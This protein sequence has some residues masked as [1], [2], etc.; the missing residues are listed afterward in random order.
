MKPNLFLIAAPRTGSTQLAFLLAS[1]PDV[2]IPPIKE[3]NFFSQH[4]YP[5]DFVAMRHLNDVDPAAYVARKSAKRMQFA[6]F[7]EQ[8]HYEYLF[9]GLNARYRLDG[10]TTYM[11]C[12]GAAERIFEYAPDAKLII[13]TRNPVGRALSH[14]KLATRSGQSDRSLREEIE[15]EVNGTTPLPG[16]FLIRQSRYDAAIAHY[17]SIFPAENILEMTF[18]EM[19]A[20][21]EAAL[22]KVAAFLGI[23]PEKFDLSVDEQ[24]AGDSVRFERLN[25]WLLRS[26]WKNRLRQFLPIK[27]KRMIKK[28]WF[29]KNTTAFAEEDIALLRR[30]IEASP[31]PSRTRDQMAS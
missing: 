24:N 1:H 8:A 25:V 19:V 28:V 21:T 26:G 27:L 10:S 7:R 5:E 15:L 4:E 3:P 23:D 20:D 18:E 2:D 11:H 17:K 12:D 9:Q 30:H 29:K 16:R 13:Q 14:Y 31:A 6:I 22:A